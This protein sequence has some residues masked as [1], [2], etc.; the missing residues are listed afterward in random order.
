MMLGEL[1]RGGGL[2]SYDPQMGC[3]WDTILTLF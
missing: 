1:S 3:A 2:L